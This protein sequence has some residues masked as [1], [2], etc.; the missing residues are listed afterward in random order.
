MRVDCL[1]SAKEKYH[2]DLETLVKVTKHAGSNIDHV[3][4]SKN[5]DDVVAM[6]SGL[7]LPRGKDWRGR[8]R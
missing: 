5:D 8:L 7:T 6:W 3:N 1:V 4:H 2:D